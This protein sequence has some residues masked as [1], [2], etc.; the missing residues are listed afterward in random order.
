MIFG[1]GIQPQ[2]YEGPGC[3]IDVMPTLLGIM[4]IGY[5]FD[6]FGQDLLRQPREMVFYSADNQIV[7]RNKEQVF[8]YSP[9]LQ[10]SFVY[11]VM[12][13]RQLAEMK[14]VESTQLLKRY[15]FAMIE[16]AEFNERQSRNR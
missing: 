15:V 4:G 11:G 7:A 10:K 16:T 3:Q 6:G 14:P 9:E 5:T 2:V 13:G 1:K 8:I 12:P